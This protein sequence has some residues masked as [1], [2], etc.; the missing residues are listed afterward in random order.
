M[1]KNKTTKT[2]ANFEKFLRKVKDEKRRKDYFKI[3]DI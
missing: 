2:E 1:S 3:L